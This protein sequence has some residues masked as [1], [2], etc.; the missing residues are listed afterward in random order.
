MRA[1]A[2]SLLET[3]LETARTRERI[4]AA[5]PCAIRGAET[6]ERKIKPR[7]ATIEQLNIIVGETSDNLELMAVL[8]TWT[9]CHFGELGE[10]RRGDVDL[11]EAV[12][13]IRRA[14]V[15]VD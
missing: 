6:A 10:L 5:N 14:A 3:I 2:Y 1:H 15:R 7:P 12:I 4:I 9:V 11:D 8:A 13:R